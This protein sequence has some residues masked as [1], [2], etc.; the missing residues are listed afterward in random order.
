VASVTAGSAIDA[1]ARLL[2]VDQARCTVC[3][4]KTTLTRALVRAQGVGA[5]ARALARAL[6][7]VGASPR[8]GARC[9]RIDFVCFFF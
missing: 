3:R 8:P 1:I 6:A 7:S 2:R 9:D 5:V 4:D